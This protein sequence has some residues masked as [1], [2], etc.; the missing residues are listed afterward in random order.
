MNKEEFS[1]PPSFDRFSS[2]FFPLCLEEFAEFRISVD[3]EKS[4]VES[5][6]GNM[7]SLIE[8][9]EQIITCP[10]CSS[11]HSDLNVL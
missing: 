10:T 8:G 4:R 11:V 9:K 7:S 1:Y 5:E 2:I 3:S 6:V